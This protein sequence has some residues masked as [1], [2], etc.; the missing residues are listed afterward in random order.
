L[1]ILGI[2]EIVISTIGEVALHLFVLVATVM[3]H[4]LYY[5]HAT[6]SDTASM[7]AATVVASV[8]G[9]AEEVQNTMNN[10]PIKNEF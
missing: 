5:T 3:C 8:S 7:T 6:I 4:N 2:E 10:I 9:I 1:I